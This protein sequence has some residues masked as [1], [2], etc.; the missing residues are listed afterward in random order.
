VQGGANVGGMNVAADSDPGFESLRQWLGDTG[1]GP[2]DGK[3]RHLVGDVSRRRYLRLEADGPDAE[4]LVLAIYPED[5]A[6]VYRRFVATTDLLAKAGVPTP[7]ILAT[8]TQCRFMAL[9]DAG[10]R[11]LYGEPV[12][13]TETERLYSEVVDLLPRLQTIELSTVGSLSPPLDRELFT[14]ELDQTW[15]LFFAPALAEF[16]SL[17]GELRSALETTLT[18][19]EASQYV[20]CHRDLMSRNVQITRRG[21]VVLDHQDLRLGPPGYDLASLLHDSLRLSLRQRRLLEAETLDSGEPQLLSPPAG[22]RAAAPQARLL[23][24]GCVAQRTSKIIGTFCS[25]ALRGGRRHLPLIPAAVESLCEALASSGVWPHA[26]GDL[27]PV[28]LD[29]WSANLDDFGRG[30][31]Q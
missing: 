22:P 7:A 31:V 2:R 18:R 23:Y 11:S 30:R 14:R 9:E 17:E 1:V 13:S 25:F 21:I 10:N 26:E 20:V 27:A 24:W 8:D 6:G 5:M 12:G 16:R 15:H 3:I 28:L 29:Y 4:S 19:L